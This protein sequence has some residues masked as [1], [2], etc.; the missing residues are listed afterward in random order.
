MVLSLL[1][2]CELTIRVMG[3]C[4]L[5][6]RIACV[7]RLNVDPDLLSDGLTVVKR[8]VKIINVSNQ[9]RN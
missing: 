6:F 8:E 7:N 4:E 2:M 1:P 5:R 3:F 9:L